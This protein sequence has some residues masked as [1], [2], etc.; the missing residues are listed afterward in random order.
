VQQAYTA[1][2][3][4]RDRLAQEVSVPP[5][6]PGA[7]EALV[8]EADRALRTVGVSP[9]NEPTRLAVEQTLRALGEVRDG[10]ALRSATAGAAH[11][12]GADVEAQLLRALASLDAAL[13]PLR[14]AGGGAPTT[15]FEA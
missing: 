9:P 10:L 11:A 13:G 6:A 5:A 15:G 1:S 14:E 12:G 4:V 8:D 2:A 3:A 7:L